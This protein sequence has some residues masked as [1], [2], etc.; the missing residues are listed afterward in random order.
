MCG[1]THQPA[2]AAVPL[3]AG[4]DGKKGKD[5][6]YLVELPAAGGRA[7]TGSIAGCQFMHVAEPGGLFTVCL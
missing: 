4:R 3:T 2:C 6:K 7:V 1:A 5:M